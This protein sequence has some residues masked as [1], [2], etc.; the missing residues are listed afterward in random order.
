[1]TD[2]TPDFE[3]LAALWLDRD[4]RSQNLSPEEREKA[5]LRLAEAL[6]QRRDST[7][8]SD[9]DV[10]LVV[11]VARDEIE[12]GKGLSKAALEQLSRIVQERIEEDPEFKN[13]ES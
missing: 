3:A 1:M 10:G 8:H 2:N 5:V 11:N 7:K 13:R 9:Q 12:E 6:R 4:P